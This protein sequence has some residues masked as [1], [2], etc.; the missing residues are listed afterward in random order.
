M[1]F[2]ASQQIS[3]ITATSLADFKTPENVRK[4]R[5]TVMNDYLD[6]A[7]DDPLSTDKRA[8]G[9]KS[10]GNVKH[11]V[12]QRRRHRPLFSTPFDAAG[13]Q[14]QHSTATSP[15]NASL[16]SRYNATTS[17]ASSTSVNP[18]EYMQIRHDSVTSMK[19]N[20]ITRPKHSCST[21]L[22]PAIYDP[23]TELEGH[24]E[25]FNYA[26]GAETPAQIDIEWLRNNCA[27]FFRTQGAALGWFAI[28]I[29][30]PIAYLARL[31]LTAPFTDV[32]ASELSQP[33]G[34]PRSDTRLT[35]EIFDV[36]PRMINDKLDDPAQRSSDTTI[37]S[38]VQLF[39]GQMM[40]CY[41]GLIGSHQLALTQMTLARG[42]LNNLGTKG[43]VA[44]SVVTVQ[45]EAA[46]LMDKHS[47]GTYVEWIEARLAGN[48]QVPYPTPEGPLLLTSA[49]MTSFSSSPCYSSETIEMI[50][51]MQELTQ[52]VLRLRRLE[53]MQR[54]AST[55]T[56]SLNNQNR[57]STYL[58]M[59]ETIE[60]VHKMPARTMLHL[61]IG[62]WVY[63]AVR[64]AAL[65]YSHC[66]W[67][68][69][70]LHVRVS[71]T[72]CAVKPSAEKIYDA[73][74][75]VPVGDLWGPLAGVLYWALM[76]GAAACHQS[77]QLSSDHTAMARSATAGKRTDL[78]LPLPFSFTHE[79]EVKTTTAIALV[80]KLLSPPQSGEVHTPD[81]ASEALVCPADVSTA[82]KAFFLLE[83]RTVN[84]AKKLFDSYARP[85]LDDSD[86]HVFS[87]HVDLD[88]VSRS[89]DGSSKRIRSGTTDRDQD[90]EA[91]SKARRE[92]IRRYLTANAI[93]TSLL[94]R[95]DHEVAMLRSV[96]TLSQVAAWLRR[97]ET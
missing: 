19:D 84:A 44:I 76:V 87:S 90:K 10:S 32:M 45:L 29:H 9:K 16:S 24:L 5:T 21:V 37:L 86:S 74:R 59:A 67:E 12:S 92:H 79:H 34:F 96:A 91:Q 63:E 27:R 65:L 68:R 43:A 26:Q 62:A 42:G 15:S 7:K 85:R 73:V 71:C 46:V 55:T 31:C 75:R 11:V 70:S 35:L 20:G 94:L 93:R 82:P 38:V 41:L 49:D 25:A 80:D 23:S 95:F 33:D 61:G 66:I 77:P 72:Y 48:T 39:Y 81:E 1:A 69:R 6:K 50:R 56:M 88:E 89:N 58:K 54:Q 8:L 60:K 57:A 2:H 47:D 14:P 40:T 17:P 51:L 64:Q 18:R 4:V 83:Q 53:L 52:E 97:E 3:F 28:L 22:L 30:D 13:P 36:I 78:T